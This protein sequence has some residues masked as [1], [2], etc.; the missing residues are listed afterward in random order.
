VQ[1]G[2][3]TPCLAPCLQ[4]S[5]AFAEDPDEAGG[6]TMME[7]GAPAPPLDSKTVESAFMAETAGAEALQPRM[8]EFGTEDIVLVDIATLTL[9]IDNLE[10]LLAPIP[11][12]TDPAPASAAECT[13]TC[14]MPHHEAI[15]T[16]H[17][18]VLATRPDAIFPDANGSMAVD[19]YATSEHIFPIDNGAICWPSRQQEDVSS[20]TPKYDNIAATHSGKE[21]LRPSSPVSIILGSF[22]AITNL[23]SDN[24]PP[25]AFMRN[26]HSHP[27]D[28]AHQHAAQPDPTSPQPED[29]MVA[30]APSNPLSSAKGMHFVASLGLCAK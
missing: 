3:N 4:A 19:W 27:P 8:L 20:T 1:L 10:P 11:H 25:L 28:H 15:N 13:I 5:E 21:A 2:T 29:D 22:K 26:H 7:D 30:D 24:I 17:W 16:S 23:F 18:A 9:N 14:N 6:V 12:L